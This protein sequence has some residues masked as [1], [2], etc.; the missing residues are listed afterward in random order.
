MS[1]PYGKI[2]LLAHEDGDDEDLIAHTD[3]DDCAVLF[4][5]MVIPLPTPG[6]SME[7]ISASLFGVFFLEHRRLL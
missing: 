7:Y 4:W 1:R 3:T 5:T 6:T 2:V